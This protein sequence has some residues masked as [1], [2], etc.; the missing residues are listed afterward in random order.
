M[1]HSRSSSTQ[2]S[3]LFICYFI[4]IFMIMLNFFFH[5]LFWHVAICMC[6]WSF[7]MKVSVYSIRIYLTSLDILYVILINI[8]VSLLK[9]YFINYSETFRMLASKYYWICTF[10]PY[11]KWIYIPLRSY[12]T[13]VK[14]V[15]NK[16]YSIFVSSRSY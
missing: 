11:Q 12:H 4:S 14:I 6:E 10:I 9:W 3:Y 1:L 15:S 5:F 2:S 16:Q 8:V 7:L 13:R